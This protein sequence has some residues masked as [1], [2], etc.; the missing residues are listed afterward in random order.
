MSLLSYDVMNAMTLIDVLLYWG[1]TSANSLINFCHLNYC[2]E[3][4][5]TFH[6]VHTLHSGGV[7]SPDSLQRLWVQMLSVNMLDTV[8][9]GG[10]GL[11]DLCN[12]GD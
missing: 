7:F 2:T 12:V 9:A 4:T 8:P 11:T 10:V 6:Y 3:Y 1:T 5:I